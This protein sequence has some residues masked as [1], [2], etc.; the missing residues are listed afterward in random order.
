MTKT[1]EPSGGIN[2]DGRAVQQYTAPT[3]KSHNG[4]TVPGRDPKRGEENAT[5]GGSPSSGSIGYG[6]QGPGATRK[7]SGLDRATGAI[8]DRQA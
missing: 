6:P 5:F 8:W 1:S 3:S 7:A 2:F 4:R